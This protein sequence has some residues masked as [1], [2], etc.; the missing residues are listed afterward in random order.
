MRVFAVIVVLS[1]L[2][3]PLPV[4]GQTAYL[5]RDLDARE[6]FESIFSEPDPLLALQGRVFFT[7]RE[8]SAGRELWVTDGTPHGSQML[9][10]ACPGACD[11]EP[12][13][14]GSAGN[15]VFF[16]ARSGETGNHH[17]WRS[18]GTRRGT[19]LLSFGGA[20]L[21]N[22]S[23]SRA[24]ALGRTFLFSGCAGEEACGLWKTDG[25]PA[26]TI[27]IREL[28]S[29]F[30]SAI[31]S[32]VVSGNRLFFIAGEDFSS[33]GLALWT[34]DGTVAGTVEVG[35]IGENAHTLVGAGARVFFLGENEELGIE[36]WTS[37]GTE[38]G[39]RPLTQFPRDDP[40]FRWLKAL[41]N[42]VYFVAD[43]VV[44]G[45]ELWTSDGTIA[46]TRR[47]TDF[48]FADPFSFE[49][50]VRQIEQLGSQLLFIA[51][52]GLSPLK[53]WTISSSAAAGSAVP[54]AAI[55]ATE[56][57]NSSDSAVLVKVGNRVLF[58]ANDGVHGVEIWS[59]NGTL[60][61]T[62]LT[63]DVCPGLCDSYHSDSLVPLLGS[64]FFFGSSGGF[65][66]VDLWRS[67]GTP[68]GT[69]K[70]VRETGFPRNVS[71]AALGKTVFYAAQDGDESEELWASDGTAPGT[72]QLTHAARSVGSSRPHDLVVLGNHVVFSACV[73]D[74]LE[75]VWSSTGFAGDVSSITSGG[76]SC[77]DSSQTAVAG[78]RAYFWHGGDFDA[79]L[80]STTEDGVVSTLLETGEFHFF[81]SRLVPLKGK[82]YFVFQPLGES[83]GEVW[84]SDGTPQG[85]H[86]AFDLPPDIVAAPFHPVT[87]G[88]ELYFLAEEEDGSSEALWR[89]D[90]TQAG[91]R[92]LTDNLDF[93]DLRLGRASS[94][95]LFFSG[96]FEV[97]LWRTDGTA[98]GTS[99][100]RSD[101]RGL[102]SFGHY[103][104]APVSFQNAA[105]FLAASS[106]EEGLWRSD[107][108]AQG[109]FLVKS[110]DLD[111]DSFDLSS[112]PQVTV[113]GDRLF[114]NVDDGV[115]GSELWT[116]D[117]TA[118]GTSMV[119][120]I[121]P[122]AGTSGISNLKATGGRM[123]FS[124]N[125]GVHGF[126]LWTSDGTSAGTRLVQDLA[127]LGA[128]SYPSEPTA[129]GDR[130]VW[131]A[132]DGLTG[133]E[134]WALPLA[135]P[136][137]CQPSPTALCLG[138]RFRIEAI[139]RDPSANTGPGHAVAL[140]ADTGYFWFF[141]QAN[142]EVVI[143]ALDAQAVNG[144]VW[145][146]YGALSNVEYTLT[147]TD[148][149][150]GLTRRYFNPAGRFAS[151]ADTQGFGPL[152]AY[153]TT[154]IASAGPTVT[155][156]EIH[157]DAAKA[158]CV[159]SS[160]RLCLNGGRFAV[161]A[162]WKIPGQSGT[163]KAVR[164]TGDTGYLWF[165]D[166]ANV[167]VVLKVL[168]GRPVN[169]KFWV[170][171]GALS[172]VEYTITVTDTATGQV[173]TYANPKGRLASFGD[174]GAF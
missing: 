79:E 113:F 18:D 74:F 171:A 162:A 32:L 3:I 112:P 81:P 149:Q 9:V 25:T 111:D 164:L 119:K 131:S 127:P 53:L 6:S 135:G 101:F 31:R 89:S 87:A 130:L 143:K 29:F 82:I 107:G 66:D 121:L 24:A 106:S 36:L 21:T 47:I 136:T 126:E 88:D 157:R 109:T 10:D 142:V 137:G 118:A 59:T 91:T 48:G 97:S 40:E 64:A 155:S 99:V 138:G 73:D 13:I 16:T 43:D 93:Q 165:F 152:G 85:T 120:D 105:Y 122:G 84:T 158:P 56:F 60:G 124:A 134:L 96:F 26:G 58:P 17:L 133:Q 69:R 169:G 132:D 170:F 161:E 65:F 108:T 4:C 50:N 145:V 151:V 23:S 102:S 129:V 7:A 45:E 86:R 80:R 167:E 104:T 52:D 41:S 172:D 153:S 94:T 144:H 147:V 117:G 75:D 19:F 103:P 57:C 115:H 14:V 70:F 154:L 55:C 46:G 90:G 42:K 33:T 49:T 8:R 1:S 61:G 30:G 38:A 98:F 139:W 95:V 28:E 141:D 54:L 83:R 125:D 67:D 5:V 156:T 148:V 20:D 34:S 77:G 78:D 160:T 140:S 163:A 39:T 174:T 159:E 150:T 62:S 11:S 72:R 37:D 27:L 116:S 166:A 15:L 63:R 12:G 35:T 22:V 92:K 100:L 76:G 71:L 128:S 168:D 173:K 44:H 2:L 51:T 110:F 123:W 114:F 68:Q 146:F